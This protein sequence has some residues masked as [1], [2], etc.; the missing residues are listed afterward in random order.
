MTVRSWRAVIAARQADCISAAPG[1]RRRGRLIWPRSGESAADFAIRYARRGHIV[2]LGCG[3]ARLRIRAAA[4]GLRTATRSQAVLRLAAA[5]NRTTTAR[6]RCSCVGSS[7]PLAARQRRC[8]Q[9]VGARARVVA[10]M[11]TVADGALAPPSMGRAAVDAQQRRKWKHSS[12]ADVARSRAWPPMQGMPPLAAARLRVG[13]RRPSPVLAGAPASPA[14]RPQRPS[15]PALGFARHWSTTPHPRKCIPHHQSHTSA[16]FS[17]RRALSRAY[18]RRVSRCHL[19]RS[20]LR[21]LARSNRHRRAPVRCRVHAHAPRPGTESLFARV[22]APRRTA[23]A[24][25]TPRARPPSARNGGA[26]RSI[27]QTGRR[28]SVRDEI[29][30]AARRGLAP[31]PLPR[32]DRASRLRPRARWPTRPP[33]RFKPRR[34]LGRH[35]ARGTP[36]RC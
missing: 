4:E 26:R 1:R 5:A 33:R 11:N 30:R 31:A 24:R 23:F 3:W 8:P 2:G 15:A 19:S 16:H 25:A 29:A 18:D 17:T 21:A 22:R 28:A 36:H 7:W 27:R 20:G 35:P 14:R 6:K 10:S 12:V 13:A 32:S 34:Y 9:A